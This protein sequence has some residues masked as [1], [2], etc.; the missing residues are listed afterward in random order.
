MGWSVSTDGPV[1]K[2]KVRGQLERDRDAILATRATEQHTTTP[3]DAEAATVEVERV[4]AGRAEQFDAAL[5]A[6]DR[7]L[8]D[9]GLPAEVAVSV[10]TRT[11]NHPDGNP[12]VPTQRP[13]NVPALAGAPKNVKARPPVGETVLVRLEWGG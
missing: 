6:V 7:L 3:R 13:E 2:A 8:A 5:E 4:P 12:T 10:R 9:P 1:P 11:R